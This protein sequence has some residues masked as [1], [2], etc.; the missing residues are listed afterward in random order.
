MFSLGEL[1]VFL[2]SEEGEK[3]RDSDGLSLNECN[4]SKLHSN[5]CQNILVK[6]MRIL[7]KSMRMLLELLQTLRFVLCVTPFLAF[8]LRIKC[9]AQREASS[10]FR[11]LKQF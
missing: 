7:L 1:K 9:K 5:S 11:F 3:E 10:F 4:R 2:K 8:S 6:V